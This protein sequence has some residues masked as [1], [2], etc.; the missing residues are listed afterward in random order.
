M[1]FLNE[2]D[3][4]YVIVG[5]SAGALIGLQF[6]VMTL[7]SDKRQ[8]RTAD[9]GAAF[10]TPTVVHFSAVLLLSAILR[11]PWQS[12]PRLTGL[13]GLMGLAGVVYAVVVARRMLRQNAYAPVLEDWVFHLA[14]PFASYVLLAV[15]PVA[16]PTHTRGAFFCIGAASLLLLFTGIHNAWDAVSYQVFMNQERKQPKT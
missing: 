1:S 6:V 5:S 11:A 7:I 12:I 14:F 2:W 4:F 16:A 15:T 8:V 10:G 3:S 13:L 9:A